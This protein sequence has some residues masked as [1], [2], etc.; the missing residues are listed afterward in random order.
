M[1][2]GFRPAIGRADHGCQFGQTAHIVEIM[3]KNVLQQRKFAGFQIGEIS[4]GNLS[5][6]QIILSGFAENGFLQRSQ[7]ASAEPQFI[8]AARG[9]QQIEVRHIRYMRPDAVHHHTRFQQRQIKTLSVKRDERIRLCGQCGD[10]AEDVHLLRV[11]PHDVLAN[12]HTARFNPS[13]ADFKGN[14]SRAAAEPRRFRIQKQ[15]S[16]HAPA[17]PIK[18][19][20]AGAH[21][22]KRNPVDI[23]QCAARNNALPAE[24]AF[25]RLGRARR[26]RAFIFGAFCDI[27]QPLAQIPHSAISLSVSRSAVF[28]PCSPTSFIGPVQEGH[29]ASQ[30]QRAIRSW[31]SLK[32]SARMP[33]TRSLRPIPPA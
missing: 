11:I 2:K 12:D 6:R 15:Q 7:A 10:F 14:R 3:P 18:I 20:I 30:G 32:I 13:H 9:M 25:R 17:I 27:H 22:F 26:L 1:P 29:P 21:V 4:F 31:T 5:A 33:K 16:L 19:R 28:L 24:K 8:D 23:P